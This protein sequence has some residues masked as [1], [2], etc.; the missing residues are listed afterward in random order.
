[1][2]NF[3]IK[4]LNQCRHIWQSQISNIKKLYF[5]LALFCYSGR[6]SIFSSGSPC[7]DMRVTFKVKRWLLLLSFH[8]MVV[9]K[10]LSHTNKR[11]LIPLESKWL[12]H[13]FILLHFLYFCPSLSVSVINP[14]LIFKADG[15]AAPI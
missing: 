14:Q 4:I 12:A 11:E 10:T 9:N 15:H 1:M 6:F 3:I 7:P 8:V 2:G 13:V 5:F